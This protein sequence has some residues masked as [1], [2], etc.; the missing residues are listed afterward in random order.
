MLLTVQIEQTWSEYPGYASLKEVIEGELP[1]MTY[2]AFNGLL[3]LYRVVIP[4][5]QQLGLDPLP[6]LTTVKETGGRRYIKIEWRR[7]NNGA[8][9]GQVIWDT[10]LWEG[11]PERLSVFLRH[12]SGTEGYKGLAYDLP[13]LQAFLAGKGQEYASLDE[14]REKLGIETIP[15]WFDRNAWGELIKRAGV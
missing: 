5:L 13:W 1:R 2:T 11:V 10:T 6:Y 9:V 4:G 12:F 15:R 7:Y 8:A 3:N 14:M